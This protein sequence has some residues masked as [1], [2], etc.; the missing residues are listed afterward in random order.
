MS[1]APLLAMLTA[2]RSTTATGLVTFVIQ[3]GSS[4]TLSIQK[5]Q[6]ELATAANIKD[7]ANRKA[8]SEALAAALQQLKGL[9]T[10]P[11]TGIAL[12]SG[13]CI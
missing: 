6:Q 12:F 1:T 7:R 8:V 5:L 9:S 11:A 2:A 10:L 3:A 13:Q 4:L